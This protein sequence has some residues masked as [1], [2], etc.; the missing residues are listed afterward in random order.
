M[1]RTS[2]LTPGRGDFSTTRR[3]SQ[4]YKPGPGCRLP[5]IRFPGAWDPAAGSVCALPQANAPNGQ[6][7]VPRSHGQI[8]PVHR[9]GGQ[10]GCQQPLS[11][12]LSG[13][14]H[15]AAIHQGNI[16]SYFGPSLEYD[17]AVS[18]SS[19][20]EADDELD[21]ANESTSVQPIHTARR[22]HPGCPVDA[23]RY[24]LPYT[25]TTVGSEIGRRALNFGATS[26][27]VPTSG[28]SYTRRLD[29]G[30]A[31]S[32]GRLR[33]ATSGPRLQRSAGQGISSRMPVQ[34]APGAQWRHGCRLARQVRRSITDRASTR[35]IE[36]LSAYFSR[37]FKISV[38][39]A[40]F[41][42]R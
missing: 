38:G 36:I 18:A 34:R 24:R 8:P 22:P 17:S 21:A 30:K 23:V 41:G 9:E 12:V 20:D 35:T 40:D 19:R 33:A 11:A 39:H 3:L 29:Q 26:S 13:R 28:F 32:P 4:L 14:L 16:L 5:L 25:R 10:R 7:F 15:N 6:V 42:A 2:P 1:I 37:R 31:R 27:G